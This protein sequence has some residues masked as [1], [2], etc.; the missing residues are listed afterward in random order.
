[1]DKLGYDVSTISVEQTQANTYDLGD[2]A[3]SEINTISIPVF[4]R[5]DIVKTTIT[6]P[7]PFPSAITGYSWEGSYNNRGISPLR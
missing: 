2:V 4:S 1:M 5:G 7:D 6:A 3:V